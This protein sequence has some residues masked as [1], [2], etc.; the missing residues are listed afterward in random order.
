M[1]CKIFESSSRYELE[2]KINDFI[3]YKVEVNMS[4][5]SCTVGYSTYYTAIVCLDLTPQK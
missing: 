5:S 3:N 1:E 2:Q 4:F